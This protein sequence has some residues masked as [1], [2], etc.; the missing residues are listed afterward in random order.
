M[1]DA[2]RREAKKMQDPKTKT[3]IKGF[4]DFYR[5][6]M[7]EFTPS[8]INEYKVRLDL[9][10]MTAKQSLLY[11]KSFQDFFI[12]HHKP[13]SRPIAAKDDPSV[14]VCAADARL[15]VYQRVSEAQKIWIKGVHFSIAALLG[16]DA[17]PQAIE[18]ASKFADGA[19]ASFRLSPQD[20][21]RYQSPVTGTVKWFKEL[22]GDYYQ[23]DPLA[24]RSSV[25]ILT[26]NARSAVCIA[27]REFGDVL[28]VAI[29]ATEVGTVKLS[30]KSTTP[31]AQV[32]KGDE[33]GIFEFGGSSIVIAFEQGRIEFDEDL[34]SV[35][36]QA[37][38]MDVEVGMSLGKATRPS[39]PDGSA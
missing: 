11:T 36:K 13:E 27:T 20:Y 1:L 9:N 26:R 34:L 19:I 16:G 32:Q 35:S 25:D 10:S 21:Y 2:I 33:V 23:V 30:E 18:E 17:V 22:D 6:N 38:M 5:I 12:R 31:G 4:V 14:A 29:G 8:D 7:N 24:L 37:I 28:F 3:Q 39:A 15:V